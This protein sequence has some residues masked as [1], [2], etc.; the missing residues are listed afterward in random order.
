MRRALKYPGSKWNI[1]GKLWTAIRNHVI[2]WAAVFSAW[3]GETY[4]N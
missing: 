1:A 4:E 3:K 2:K